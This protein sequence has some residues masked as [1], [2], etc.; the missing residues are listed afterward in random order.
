LQSSKNFFNWV[1]SRTWNVIFYRRFHY[2]SCHCISRCF[3]PLSCSL[4]QLILHFN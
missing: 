4:R 3:C 2:F 1:G